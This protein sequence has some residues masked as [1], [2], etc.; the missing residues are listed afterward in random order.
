MDAEVMHA[1]IHAMQAVEE[2]ER[3]H[4][5]DGDLPEA[6]LRERER[7][8][9]AERYPAERQRDPGDEDER[10]AGERRKHAAGAEERPE[11]RLVRSLHPSALHRKAAETPITAMTP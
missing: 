4:E 9:V 8:L 6:V 1:V 11:D 3:D 5:E 7:A 10:R 2:E